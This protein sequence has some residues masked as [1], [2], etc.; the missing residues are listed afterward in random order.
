MK[1]S[2]TLQHEAMQ[3]ICS[4]FQKNPFG[5]KHFLLGFTRTTFQ[6]NFTVTTQSFELHT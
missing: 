5:S 2:H 6:I 4:K 3:Y 1:F